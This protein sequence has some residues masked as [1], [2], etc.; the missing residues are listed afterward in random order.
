M[1]NFTQRL[2]TSLVTGLLACTLLVSCD[3]A[4]KDTRGTTGTKV[5]DAAFAQDIQGARVLV[6]SKTS[7]W[8]H[9]SI[10]AGI[11]ALEKLGT[12]HG[13]T[14]VSTEDSSLFNDA[15][16][17]T[18]N[19]I[20]FLNTTQD[21]LNEDQEVAMERFI[22]AG[23]GFVGIHSAADTEWDGDWYWFRNLVGGVFKS[24]PNSPSNVQRAQL[25]VTAHQHPSTEHFPETFSMVDEWYDYRDLYPF[26]KDLLMLD[27]S[28]YIGGLH[29]EYHPIAWYHDYDGGRSFYTG[30]GHTSEIFSDKMFLDHLLGGLKYAVGGKPKLD[31]SRARP[32]HNR[33][34]KKTLVQ[35]L[36][37]PMSFDFFANGDA[38]IAERP[39]T[40]KLV[41]FKTGEIRDA[42]QIEVGYHGYF[43][44]GLIGLGVPPDFAQTSWIYVGYNARKE[45]GSYW[46]RLAR[47]KWQD[48]QINAASEQVLLEYPI[49]ETCCHTG[50]DI[51][52]G[53][54]GEVYFSTGDNTNPHEQ[55]GYAPID[56]REDRAHFDALRGAGN[57]Q[58]LRGKILRIIPQ[59]DGT[60]KIPT[61]NLFSD[62]N[63]GRPEIYVMGVRNPFTVRYD[64]DT[65]TLF[66]GDVGPDASLNSE[67]QGSRGYDEIN[68]VTEAG[69][70]GWPLMIGNNQ[71]YFEY[72]FETEK[73]G[74]LFNPLA[75]MNNSPRNTGLKQL[76]PA[77]PAW[78]WY[79]YAVSETFPE[80]GSGG[81]TP[82][83]ADLYR[84]KNYPASNHRYPEY[85]DGKLFVLDFMRN[86]VK[87]VSFDDFGRIQKIEPFAPQINYTLPIAARFAPDGSLYVLEYGT[88]W[89][90]GNPDS[91]LSRIEYVG[92]GNR[93]PSP[94]ITVETA[95]GAVPLVTKVSAAKSVDLD[96]DDISFS[97]TSEMVGN[98]STRKSLGDSETIT[99]NFTEAG[100]YLVRLTATDT[101]GSSATAET[102]LDVGNEPANIN[103]VL[104]GN[105]SF[106]WPGTRSLDYRIEI[107]DKE[108]G[109]ITAKE[110]DASKAVVQFDFGSLD[111]QSA[112]EGHQT[113]GAAIVGKELVEANACTACHQV[114]AA[115]VGPSFTSVAARYQNDPQGLAYLIKKIGDGG[116]G[117]WGETAMPSFAHLNEDDRKA[118]ATYVLSYGETIQVDSLPLSGKLALR[119]HK[120]TQELFARD[121]RMSGEEAA[122]FGQAYTLSVSYTDKGGDVIGPITVSESLSLRVPRF[123][124]T[125][126]FDRTTVPNDY[127]LGNY[128]QLSTLMTTAGGGAWRVAPLGEYDLR[129]VKSVLLGRWMTKTS[130]EWAY[131][132]RIDQPDGP[133]VATGVSTETEL[134]AYAKERITFSEAV[135]RHQVYLAVRP[136]KQGDT[137]LHLLDI[138]FNQ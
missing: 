107:T 92:P 113:A 39:G 34:V 40:F 23:G 136:L 89:F 62:S 129:G 74:R 73:S 10:P 48:H 8:R 59:E 25:N 127:K 87:V 1:N 18:Y 67:T 45:D 37:E 78:I 12:E 80:M 98:S 84:S 109:K 123:L 70:F 24:H 132:L 35:G 19:A 30:L 53:K 118:L 64:G 68:R 63:E 20:V 61:G 41:D 2:T 6:F 112:S 14:V 49:E 50:G 97:W 94:A 130:T 83:I 110:G 44:W 135:G 17:S 65:G 75:P 31:Y 15:E 137:E 122:L 82:L 16:L 81:R 86:W 72:D 60:Y 54:D 3:E 27:E 55:N 111:S 58:D 51:A 96:G 133:V 105:S 88:A 52:F 120:I 131:E 90:T 46:Q 125:S 11:A 119:E 4:E 104:D 57:T 32:E 138:S 85:Y 29:G 71:P 26:K 115:S 134:D 101:H 116:A 100:S 5:S 106:Y 126:L 102:Q 103:I 43:E 7:G 128:F 121:V 21:V 38:L 114:D 42:G 56:M 124:L 13:F 9:D 95:Q 76:P 22:Q 93:P 69:N 108:D 91:G 79:P 36:N 47:F 33:F 117:V 77:Q 99:V 28:T 66:F